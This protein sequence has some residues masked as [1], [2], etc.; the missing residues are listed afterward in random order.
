MRAYRVGRLPVQESLN[1]LQHRDHHHPP[2]RLDRAPAQAIHPIQVDV[3][4]KRAQ[5]VV[6]P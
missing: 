6:H 2:R 3:V 1:V 4:H 5:V